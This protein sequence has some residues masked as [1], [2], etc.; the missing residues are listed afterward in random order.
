M[1]LPQDIGG[2]CQ[3]VAQDLFKER[4]LVCSNG[5]SDPCIDMAYT[6]CIVLATTLFVLLG[7]LK[8][9]VHRR[10]G[11]SRVFVNKGLGLAAEAAKKQ[12]T[13]KEQE[14]CVNNLLGED[15]EEGNRLV[16]EASWKLINLLQSDWAKL[17]D[18]PWDDVKKVI[19]NEFKKVEEDW[20]NEKV[21]ELNKC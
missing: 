4:A 3:P 10:S 20:L 15:F 12:V 14:T 9:Y 21:A 13:T 11:Y 1:F 16:G 5:L 18:S 6:F 8:G 17:K 7:A 19:D 2:E